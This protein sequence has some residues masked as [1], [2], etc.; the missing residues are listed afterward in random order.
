[1]MCV[2]RGRGAWRIVV[3]GGVVEVFKGLGFEASAM[4][5]P[6]M[7]FRIAVSPRVITVCLQYRLPC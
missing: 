4:S 6:L 2:E 7:W 5:S 1:M 3:G